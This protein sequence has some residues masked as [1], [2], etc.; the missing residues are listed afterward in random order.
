MNVLEQ[1]VH[2]LKVAIVGGAGQL[3]T[4]LEREL[5]GNSFDVVAL[6]RDEFDVTAGD[7][8]ERLTALAPHV[9]VNCSAWNDV[10]GAETNAAAAT[11]VNCSGVVSLAETARRIGATF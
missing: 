9:I 4:A 3:G 10:D 7:A 2:V 5:R 6:T 1:S 11:A 8:V